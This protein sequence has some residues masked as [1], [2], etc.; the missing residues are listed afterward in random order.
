MLAMSLDSV[1]RETGAGQAVSRSEASEPRIKEFTGINEL[2]AFLEISDKP[3]FLKIG[4]NWCGPCELVDKIMPDLARE[5]AGRV[6]IIKVD[7]D[8]ARDIA[9]HFGVTGIPY[10]AYFKV[11]ETNP[12][13]TTV[14]AL[15]LQKFQALINQHCLEQGDGEVAIPPERAAARAAAAEKRRRQNEAQLKPES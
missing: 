6:N 7:S 5:F 15:G 14:G 1:R 13:A 8:S 9:N 4:A 2:L 12:E 3:S 10:V 11:R